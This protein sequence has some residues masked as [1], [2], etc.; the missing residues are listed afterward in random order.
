VPASR[1]PSSSTGE[2]MPALATDA[3][4]QA[5][6]EGLGPA[7]KEVVEHA[8]ALARLEVRLALLEGKQKLAGLGLGIGVVGRARIFALHALGSGVAALAAGLATA[9]PMWLALLIVT[10]LLVAVTATLGLL[11]V[12]AIRKGVPPVPEQAIEEARLTSEAV[13]TGGGR[14]G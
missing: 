10:A 9:L 11:G 12:R 14:R 13:R 3:R 1:S 8:S 5:G 7:A 6:D 2:A 4:L